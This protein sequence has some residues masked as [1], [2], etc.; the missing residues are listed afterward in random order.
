MSLE[1]FISIQ[2]K[3]IKTEQQFNETQGK[4]CFV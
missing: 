3:S 1:L 4:P 2:Y